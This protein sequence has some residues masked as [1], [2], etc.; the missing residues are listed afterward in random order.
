MS[1]DL[2]A[3]HNYRTFEKSLHEFLFG[4]LLNFSFIKYISVK[5]HSKVYLA[6]VARSIR[7]K[8]AAVSEY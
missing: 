3:T 6:P 1:H 5:I 2:F 4:K 8:N 7:L